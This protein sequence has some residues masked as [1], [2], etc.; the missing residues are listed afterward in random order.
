MMRGLAVIGALC[1]AGAA[2]AQDF[3]PEGTD[4][5]VR[6]VVDGEVLIVTDL[7]GQTFA[8]EVEE[9]GRL[10]ALTDCRPLRY[11]DPGAAAEQAAAR[12]AAAEMLQAMPP[13][14]ASVALA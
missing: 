13:A 7:G 4:L 10:L 8:C 14:M 11:L 9:E 6:G 3:G 12:R 5:D 1:V 2:L